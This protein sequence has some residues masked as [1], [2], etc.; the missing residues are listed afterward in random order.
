MV[1]TI[2]DELARHIAA[3]QPT[4]ALIPD[5]PKRNGQPASRRPPVIATSNFRTADSTESGREDRNDT[6]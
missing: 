2:T 6:P 3:P 4:S 1:A 5:A